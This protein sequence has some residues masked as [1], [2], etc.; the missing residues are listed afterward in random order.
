MIFRDRSHAGEELLPLLQTYKNMP[1]AIVLGLPR[2]GVVT[3]YE[4]A[5]GLNLD[6]DI[7]CPRKIGS[8]GNPE[9]AIGSLV[10]TGETFFNEDL[11]SRLGVSSDYIRRAT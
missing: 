1:N 5:K 7:I 3:A 8:P 4:I 2:G 9:L 10:D 6:L 11:I